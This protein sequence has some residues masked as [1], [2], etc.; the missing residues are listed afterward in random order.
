MLKDK[1]Y[2]GSIL[3]FPVPRLQVVPDYAYQNE[4]IVIRLWNVRTLKFSLSPGPVRPQ[5]AQP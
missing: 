2:V 5:P 4:R 3:A 1:A